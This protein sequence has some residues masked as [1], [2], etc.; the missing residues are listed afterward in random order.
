MDPI[1]IYG[2][3]VLRVKAE[4][5][6]AFDDSLE[7]LVDRMKDDMYD[8]DGIGLAAP[9]IGESV[10]LFITDHTAGEH[11]P[12][13]FVN[14]EITWYS[15]EKSDYDEGCLSIP[16]INVLINRPSSIS[17]KAQDVTG[18][19]FVMEHI[20]GLLARVIQHENDHLD[21]ILFV[22]RASVTRRAL[23]NGKLKKLAKE[24]KK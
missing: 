3:P 11:E 20:E 24:N 19:E 12:L 5:V 18:K 16:G 13:I 15:E 7:E 14:P 22:D 8:E 1:R 2:D 10:R 4:P 9:Q 21:G 23:V 6:T 17:V